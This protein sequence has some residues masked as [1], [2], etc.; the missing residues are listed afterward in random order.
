MNAAIEDANAS[1]SQDTCNIVV[2]YDGDHT[3]TRA[4]AACDFL[5]GQFWE[6]VE[7]NF[8]WWRTDFLRD[9]ALAKVA[10]LNAIAADFLIV[11]SDHRDQPSA[12]VD[13]A[14]RRCQR[15]TGNCLRRA[16]LEFSHYA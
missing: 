2:L 14:G 5:V 10:A 7:L 3:R 1:N 13:R 6:D 4:M 15:R 9:A 11:S 12:L 16:A 8:H